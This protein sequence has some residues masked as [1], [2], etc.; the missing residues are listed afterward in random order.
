MCITCI[1]LNSFISLRILSQDMEANNEPGEDIVAR[2]KIGA[3]FNK[4]LQKNKAAEFDQ[5]RALTDYHHTTAQS[6]IRAEDGLEHKGK[7]ISH[8]IQPVS[9]I[10][11]DLKPMGDSTEYPQVF[12]SSPLV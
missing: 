12:Q 8:V 5:G 9:A 10:R 7:T 3:R 11:T 1:S 2:P 6:P 4:P